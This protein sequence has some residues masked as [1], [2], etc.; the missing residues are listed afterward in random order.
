M[1]NLVSELFFFHLIGDELIT[2]VYTP[3]SRPEKSSEMPPISVV[4]NNGPE[5]CDDE[6]DCIY[7]SSGDGGPDG[8]PGKGS[9]RGKLLKF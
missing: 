7:N 2:P 4:T 5:S 1:S 6:D 3:P 8:K 9:Q